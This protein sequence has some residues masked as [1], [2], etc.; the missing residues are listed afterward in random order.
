MPGDAYGYTTGPPAE[1]WQEVLN[2]SWPDNPR[3]LPQHEPIDVTARI[4][5]EGDGETWLDGTAA[6]WVGQNV[7]VEIVDPR[8]QVRFVWVDAGDVK[9]KDPQL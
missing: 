6:R 5:F 7:C 1:H 4:V 8:L 2:A 9:R 3:G